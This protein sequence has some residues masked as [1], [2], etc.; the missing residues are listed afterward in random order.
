MIH[1]ELPQY[2]RPI[3]DREVL[4]H[5]TRGSV[6]IFPGGGLPEHYTPIAA[7]SVRAGFPSPAQPYLA[8]YL[9]FNEYLVSNPLATIGVYL[10]GD[11]LID[12]GLW[13]KDL[14]VVNRSAEAKHGNI[15]VVDIDNEFTA[16]RLIKTASGIELHPDNNSGE[17]PIIRP[18]HD[19]IVI[20]VGVAEFAI[21]KLT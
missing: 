9:D 6:V 3:T 19:S 7:D 17:Y 16:K 10:K 15:V 14:L 5:S 1:P 12:A 21:K 11:S 4:D 2:L 8:G 13:E 18:R 20:F